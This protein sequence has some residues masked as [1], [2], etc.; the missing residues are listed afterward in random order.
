MVEISF[1][2]SSLFKMSGVY[3]GNTLID[4]MTGRG[5]VL[6]TVTVLEIA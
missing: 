3:E 5:I 6:A 2:N 4:E 1:K